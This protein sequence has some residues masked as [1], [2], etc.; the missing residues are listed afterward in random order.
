[1]VIATLANDQE[2][3]H[4]IIEFSTAQLEASQKFY[5]FK[6]DFNWQPADYIRSDSNNMW[7]S[8]HH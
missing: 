5:Q 1:M 7:S 3:S 2:P 6:F 8:D 4:G